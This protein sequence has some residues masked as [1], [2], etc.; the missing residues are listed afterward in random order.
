MVLVL[1]PWSL[2]F[3]DEH[4]VGLEEP[5]EVDLLMVQSLV[6]QEEHLVGL[7]ELSE[8]DS[9]LI[10]G[11]VLQEERQRVHRRS[12]VEQQKP[13]LTGCHDSEATNISFEM[14]ESW[15]NPCQVE[16]MREIA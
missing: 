10:E 2:E 7:E 3:V 6:L 11:Q 16:E 12:D 5:H 15:V 8:I 13:W 9:L 1:V 4:L 14:K